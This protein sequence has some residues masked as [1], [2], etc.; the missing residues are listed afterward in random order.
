VPPAS[1]FGEGD[2]RDLTAYAFS[3]GEIDDFLVAEALVLNLAFRKIKDVETRAAVIR[4][5]ESVSGPKDVDR[6]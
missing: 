2:Q 3:L 1:L 6:D 4:F 5:V